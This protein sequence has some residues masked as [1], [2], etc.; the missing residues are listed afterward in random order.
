MGLL[1][2]KYRSLCIGGG[3]QETLEGT[4]TRNLRG[5]KNPIRRQLPR[6]S[7]GEPLQETWKENI[8]K[9][10]RKQGDTT[11]KNKTKQKGW[12]TLYQPPPPSAHPMISLLPWSQNQ[13]LNTP[14]LSPFLFFFLGLKKRFPDFLFP[15]QIRKKIHICSTFPTI[16]Y[17]SAQTS[18]QEGSSWTDW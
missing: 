7:R 12:W 13:L 5:R 14:L 15:P 6:N 3:W 2:Y 10:E 11:K 17:L 1:H 9:K 8:T 4:I 16:V 18:S